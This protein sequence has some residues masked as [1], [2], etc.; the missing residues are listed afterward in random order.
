[1]RRVD[2]VSVVSLPVQITVQGRAMET[3]DTSQV[4]VAFWVER[5]LWAMSDSLGQTAVTLA[6]H[7]LY[8]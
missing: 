3:E 6:R 5:P 8:L 4:S 2:F 7:M 1:M